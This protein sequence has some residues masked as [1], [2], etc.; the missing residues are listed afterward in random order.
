MAI[1]QG[2][3]FPQ[4]L[5]NDSNLYIVH[6][7]LKVPL[8]F[9]YYPGA[10]S[11]LAD[12]DLSRF[13]SSGI[14]TLVEQQSS[15]KERAVS[16]YYGSRTNRE[17]NNLELMPDSIDC[18]K[19][20]KITTITLQ[21]MADHR[22][23][24]KDAIMAIEKFL[25]TKHQ[26]DSEPRGS[27]IFGRLNFL[28]KI[29]F[30]PKAWFEAEKI[31]GAAP[32]TTK[33]IFTGS[34]N[35]GPVG[36]VVYDWKFNDETTSTVE[37]EVEKTFLN[38]GNYTISL[39]VKNYYGEDT[40]T[41][42]DMIKV[43]GQAPEEAGI[44]FLPFQNQIHIDDIIPKIRTPVNQP[45]LIE[46]PQKTVENKKTFAGELI[47]PRTSKVTDTIT[48]YTW[49][50]HDDLPHTNAHKTKALYTVGGHYDL[51]L[52]TDTAQGAYRITTYPNCIDVVE[53]TNL[54]IWI[55]E[56]KQ[57]IRSYEFG[58]VSETIKTSSNTYALRATDKFIADSERQKFEF[59]RNNGFARKNSLKSGEGGEGLLF[60]ASGRGSEDS[61]SAEQI[62]F[63]SYNAFS[64]YYKV[65][66][67]IARPWNWAAL[68]AEKDVYFIYGTTPEEPL[69][70]ISL[71]NKS[72]ITY[73]IITGG[74]I[75]DTLEHS[76]YKN[77]AHDL[78]VNNGVFTS[79]YET[80]H[81]HYSAYRTTWRNNIGYLL[82]NS[83][84]G[85]Y[86]AFR[87]FY[88]TE[89]TIGSP[90]NN[91]VKLPN[92]PGDGNKEGSLVGLSNG[93]YFF[94]NHGNTYCFNTTSGTWESV[95]SHN[96]ISRNEL[97]SLLAAS[98]SEST[99]YVNI[100]ETSFFKFNE[101]D[102]SYVTF[103]HGPINKQ[104]LMSIF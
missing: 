17:F 100:E 48:N 46:V 29:L 19:P 12:G 40:V 60:W 87:N 4:A 24:L 90:F 59:W 30:S 6:D 20:K 86:F 39:T 45:V 95:N 56:N 55:N 91:I 83:S 10:T 42:H 28:K 64:D 43:K 80:L 92:M 36:Q 53:P 84:L 11:I 96:K 93:I 103:N 98:D 61:T 22:E 89:G 33:F 67:S 88:K 18:M 101:I 54:W 27:T 13:P 16:L 38:P 1:P 82:K 26:I 21:A 57:R 85:E 99:A 5:D 70:T 75:S 23:A 49:N 31:V 51:V 63:A 97:N 76:N 71:T 69:P 3:N 50:L 7:A 65:E 77:G 102:M 52:R 74:T 58:L 68:S 15:P 62:H 8:G 72:K 41:F 37:P 25:G 2:S 78:T 32:F 81:G 35:Y 79:S 34:G 14:I 44:K 94:N 9:D 47:D 66:N 73:N 104:W